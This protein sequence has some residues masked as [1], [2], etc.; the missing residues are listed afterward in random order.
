MQITS[1]ASGVLAYQAE[2]PVDWDRT[3]VLPYVDPSLGGFGDVELTIT[4]TGDGSQQMPFAYPA[5]DL[6][7]NGIDEASKPT[8]N[9]GAWSWNSVQ[10]PYYDRPVLATL[11]DPYVLKWVLRFYYTGNLTYRVKLGARGTCAGTISIA[12]TV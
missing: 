8:F 11:T 5:T 9:G 10:I 1:G 2:N 7:F 12:R 4:F 6:R 3:E